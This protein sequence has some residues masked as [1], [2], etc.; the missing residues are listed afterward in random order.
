MSNEDHRAVVMQI[1]G[2][3]SVQPAE[4]QMKVKNAVDRIVAIINEDQGVG[5]FALALIGAEIA[6]Q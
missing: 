4:I 2:E 5:T 6:A 1:R 3:L